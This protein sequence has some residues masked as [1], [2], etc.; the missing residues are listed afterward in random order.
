[1][2]LDVTLMR[3]A[4]LNKP[5]FNATLKAYES[6]GAIV[7][8]GLRQTQLTPWFSLARFTFAWI[9]YRGLMR[10]MNDTIP[11]PLR[12]AAACCEPEDEEQRASENELLELHDRIPRKL[13]YRL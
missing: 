10:W 8:T 11:L 2:R 9:L 13:A 6:T 3:K 12:L 4:A 5:D 1:M 7:P